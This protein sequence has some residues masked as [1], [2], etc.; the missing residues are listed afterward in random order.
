MNEKMGRLLYSHP[1]R[2]QKVRRHDGRGAL[3]SCAAAVRCGRE[4]PWA[5]ESYASFC[6]CTPDVDHTRP[7]CITEKASALAIKQLVVTLK[8]Y[9]AGAMSA[10]RIADRAGITKGTF[11][12]G[13]FKQR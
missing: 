12:L 6:L 9:R 5:G 2:H 4:D 3:A 13:T 8:E 1:N 7:R 11:R 10:G